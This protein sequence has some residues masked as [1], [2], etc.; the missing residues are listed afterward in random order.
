[1]IHAHDGDAWF[2][3]TRQYSEIIGLRAQIFSTEHRGKTAFLVVPYA[4][5]DPPSASTPSY[6][7]KL[8]LEI[9][10]ES[11]L[12]ELKSEIREI[13]RLLLLNE[14]DNL[15]KKSKTNG[16][17]RIRTGDLRHVKAEDLGVFE[18]FSVGDITVRK[19]NDPSCTV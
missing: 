19:A 18:A 8:S 1:M 5:G 15:H 6:V 2:G 10:V 3:L 16:L 11:H 14:D 9:N 13:K 7:S 4:D 12:S 17:G